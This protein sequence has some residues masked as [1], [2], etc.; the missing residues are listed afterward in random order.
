[1][2]TTFLMFLCFYTIS[3]FGQNTFDSSLILRSTLSVSS[4]TSGQNSKHIFQ[5]SSGQSGVTGTYASDGYLL[6]QG[7]VQSDVWAKMVELDDVLELKVE[8]FPNPFVNEVQVNLLEPVKSGVDVILFSPLGQELEHYKFKENQKIQISL[9]HL[10]TANYFINIAT[11]TKQ[12]I[13]PLIKI[14]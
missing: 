11:N 3:F 7:F 4:I 12:I 9:A 2:K 13:Q 14:K 8:V 1:M 5:Q 10:P 6:S